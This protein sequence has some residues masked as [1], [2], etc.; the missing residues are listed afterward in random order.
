[1]INTLDNYKPFWA[2]IKSSMLYLNDK[3]EDFEYLLSVNEFV[4]NEN[5]IF[6]HSTNENRFRVKAVKA[7]S[8]RTKYQSSSVT[9]NYNHRNNNTKLT[10][11]NYK[12]LLTVIA[13]SVS[14]I[15]LAL[16][17]AEK[18]V[19]YHVKYSIEKVI[20]D[21]NF[22]INDHNSINNTIEYGYNNSIYKKFSV[23]K[24]PFI[25]LADKGNGLKVS[26]QVTISMKDIYFKI[27]CWRY[28]PCRKRN[29]TLQ[30]Y[31]E[32]KKTFSKYLSVE[33]L[34][35]RL[36]EFKRFKNYNFIEISNGKTP[37]GL[38]ATDEGEKIAYKFDCQKH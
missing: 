7:R 19:K 21:K 2:S 11:R 23:N 3:P 28:F 10:V 4:S 29:E 34:L 17:I 31:K 14:L 8:S 35:Y 36:I 16:F 37:I 38:I 26:K 5:Y 15:R 9:Y 12:S 25:K 6:K 32:T 1:M 18:F 24:N 27:S 20:I 33:Y 13:N 30:F 22:S